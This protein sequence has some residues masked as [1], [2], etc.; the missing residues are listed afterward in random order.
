MVFFR[1]LHA[2][3]RFCL[4]AGDNSWSSWHPWTCILRSLY[5]SLHWTSNASLS[6]DLA[7]T[8]TGARLS[9][10][11][12]SNRQWFWCLLGSGHRM[13]SATAGQPI[14]FYTKSYNVC[15]FRC[16]AGNSHIM[17]STFLPISTRKTLI[18]ALLSEVSAALF[19]WMTSTM[20]QSISG[21]FAKYN[22]FIFK[23]HSFFPD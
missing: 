1:R 22:I 12:V 8:I 19:T 21:Y 7:W 10:L 6:R 15:L 4:S 11:T 13:G 18:N 3:N 17:H 2:P 14:V 9:L 5:Y 20:S 16:L 23:V